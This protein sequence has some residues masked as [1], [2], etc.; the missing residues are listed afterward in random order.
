MPSNENEV[1][2]LAERAGC[3][4]WHGGN[5][6][7]RLEHNLSGP[8]FHGEGPLDEIEE[9][10]RF[11]IELHHARAQWKAKRDAAIAKLDAAH[12]KQKRKRDD[13]SLVVRTPDGKGRLRVRSRKPKKVKQ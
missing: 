1:R 10:L 2:Y 13:A 4:L 5:G 8:L 9:R 3:R 12:V 11:A 6:Y 7:Y